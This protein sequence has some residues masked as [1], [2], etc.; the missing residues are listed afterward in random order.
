[1]G[2]DTSILA[3]FLVTSLIMIG[4]GLIYADSRVADL[5]ADVQSLQIMV[6]LV[7]E[8]T[9]MQTQSIVAIGAIHGI[10]ANAN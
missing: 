3:L 7:R 5:E 2:K 4:F 6:D 1:M 9:I 8:T 10:Y